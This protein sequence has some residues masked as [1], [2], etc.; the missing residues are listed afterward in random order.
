M[1]FV[2]IAWWVQ[3]IF[4]AHRNIQLLLC[5]RKAAH[6][7]TVQNKQTISK[8]ELDMRLAMVTQYA[9]DL[10]ASKYE[11]TYQKTVETHRTES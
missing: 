5:F 10:D 9:E 2:P 8:K 4:I 7:C 6:P 1:Q 11:N 3:K